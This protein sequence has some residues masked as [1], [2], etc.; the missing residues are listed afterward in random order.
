MSPPLFRN[1][2]GGTVEEYRTVG[3]LSICIDSFT[4]VLLIFAGRFCPRAWNQGTV[5]DHRTVFPDS[6]PS[7][8]KAVSGF[9]SGLPSSWRR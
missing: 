9:A 6:K 3:M 1:G 4:A 7:S 8:N 2:N 5:F